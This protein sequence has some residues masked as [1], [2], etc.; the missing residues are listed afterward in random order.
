MAIEVKTVGELI[1]ALK[2]FTPETEINAT[3]EGVWRTPKIYRAK[4]GSCVIDA[5]DG[6]YEKSFSDGT[7]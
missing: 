4:D 2:N 1:E 5:D 6:Y 7:L 3:W